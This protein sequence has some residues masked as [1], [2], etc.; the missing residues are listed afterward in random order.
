M[1]RGFWPVV[2]AGGGAQAL[3]YFFYYSNLKHSEVWIV[4]LYLLFMP[5]LSCII[6]VACMG[7]Q[8]SAGKSLGIIILLAGG[9]VVLLRDKLHAP[10]K[11]NR[12]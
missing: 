5:V 7:E 8:L 1:N 9:A 6:G 10:A 11:E 4:K 2:I 3:I 12:G